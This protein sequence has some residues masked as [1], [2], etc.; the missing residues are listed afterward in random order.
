MHHVWLLI[1]ELETKTRYAIHHNIVDQ[2]I[3]VRT[4][5]NIQD[6]TP[7]GGRGGTPAFK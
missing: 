6:I 3:S 2:I 4:S 1:L 7:G 5:C